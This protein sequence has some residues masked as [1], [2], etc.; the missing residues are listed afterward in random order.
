MLWEART[1]SRQNRYDTGGYPCA[2]MAVIIWTRSRELS[3][4][5]RTHNDFVVK[6]TA[7]EKFPCRGRFLHAGRYRESAKTS[8]VGISALK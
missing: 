5:A 6:L 7:F 8:G 4:T 2:G 3:L 1:C